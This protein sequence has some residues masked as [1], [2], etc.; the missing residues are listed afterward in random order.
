MYTFTWSGSI[1][2]SN[3]LEMYTLY[4]NEL[5]FE[6]YLD[7]IQSSKYKLALTKFRLSSHDLM[8]EKGRH[9]NIPR[10]D[11]KCAQCNM[12]AIEDEYHFL[13]VCQKYKHLRRQ[14]LKPYYCHWPTQHKFIIIMSNNSS[15]SLVNLSKYIY[16]AFELRSQGTR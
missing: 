2:E 1:H 16:F 4:K 3:R 8:I 12:N 7:I 6:K 9:M 5:S 11:R 15:N 13:L 14:Y 10:I